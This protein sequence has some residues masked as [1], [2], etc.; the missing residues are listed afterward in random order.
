MTYHI[1]QKVKCINNDFDPDVCPN[2]P[3]K[4]IWPIVGNTYTIEDIR[5]GYKSDYWPNGATLGLVLK[6]IPYRQGFDHRAFI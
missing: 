6:E 2:P 4:D 1:G 3:P 5:I